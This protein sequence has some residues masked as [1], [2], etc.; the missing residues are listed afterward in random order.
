[1]SPNEWGPPIWTF[2]H[3]LAEKIHDDAYAELMPQLVA[4]I[5]KIC[6]YLPCPD[7]SQHAT[8]FLSRINFSNVKTKTDFKNVLYM[9][10]NTVNK[11]KF[12]RL[13]NYDLLA[14]TYSKNNVI[15]CYNNF[16]Q[17]YQTRGNI[18]LLAESFQRTLILQNFKKW[19]IVN[20]K[21][22]T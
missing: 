8:A 6:V 20:I 3:T 4:Y 5:K 9:F 21:H 15:V 14:D 19:F 7:C 22:F 11:R 13:F 2:F 18:R 17:V 10:H 16:V 1:M 12:K